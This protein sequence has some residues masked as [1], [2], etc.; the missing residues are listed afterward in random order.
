MSEDMLLNL[1]CSCARAV[2]AWLPDLNGSKRLRLPLRA[3]LDFQIEL[4]GLQKR[5]LSHL[6]V[7]LEGRI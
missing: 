1:G 6:R 4:V 5:L 2:R 3:A 7:S